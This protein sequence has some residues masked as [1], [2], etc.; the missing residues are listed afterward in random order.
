MANNGGDNTPDAVQKAVLA[1]GNHDVA[2][3]SRQALALFEANPMGKVAQSVE[4]ALR[5]PSFG[6]DG[7][8]PALP[9]RYFTEA[10][11]QLSP[12]PRLNE[13]SL[14][15]RFSVGDQ[16]SLSTAIQPPNNVQHIQ[17]AI[18]R[19]NTMLG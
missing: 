17:H 1:D 14:A 13:L 5:M 2:D 4:A 19:R 8:A 16:S 6:N 15:S 9:S 3:V 7:A 11:A 18:A 10:M 12:T